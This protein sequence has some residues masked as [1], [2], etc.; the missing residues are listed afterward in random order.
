MGGSLKHAIPYICR[1]C[2]EAIFLKSK[3]YRLDLDANGQPRCLKCRGKAIGKQSFTGWTRSH[4]L[5]TRL[6]ISASSVGRIL[7]PEARLSLKGRIPWNKGKPCDDKTKAKISAAL[8]GRPSPSKGKT[9]SPEHKAKLSLIR[10]ERPN[11]YW[12]GKKRPE[13]SG[14]NN[15]NWKGGISSASLRFRVSPEYKQWRL[16]VFRRDHFTCQRCGYKGKKIEADHIIPVA[17]SLIL[18]LDVENGQTL[19]YDCHKRKTILERGITQNARKMA[20]L[21][22]LFCDLNDPACC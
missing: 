1:E 16:A 22:P 2:K 19:C 18:G 3:P 17:V 5:A 7:T 10:T 14:Q 8:T 13:M 20:L 21:A 11:Y 6:K 4:G 15:P 9:F 12:L